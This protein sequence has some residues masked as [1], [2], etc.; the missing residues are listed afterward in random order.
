MSKLYLPFNDWTNIRHQ[1]LKNQNRWSDEVST[2]N[3]IL[4]LFLFYFCEEMCF[5][6]R[7]IFT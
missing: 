5:K 2:T 1:S 6:P 4:K 3:E 7:K